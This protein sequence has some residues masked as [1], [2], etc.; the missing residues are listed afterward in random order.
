MRK[1]TISAVETCFFPSL[2]SVARSMDENNKL[3]YDEHEN[4]PMIST[5]SCTVLLLS[6]HRMTTDALY[7]TL[8]QIRD[9]E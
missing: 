9:R 5:L 7:R 4:I 6:I 1:K 3:L 8:Y 2:I